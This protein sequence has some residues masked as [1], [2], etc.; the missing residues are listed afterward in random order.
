MPRLELWANGGGCIHET[1]LGAARRVAG[2]LSRSGVA[3]SSTR[4]NA[5]NVVAASLL[6]WGK[7]GESSCVPGV[8]I[9]GCHPY[10]RFV[11]IRA[12]RG[13]SPRPKEKEKAYQ[14]LNGFDARTS[15]ITTKAF[16]VPQ[17]HSNYLRPLESFAHGALGILR[18]LRRSFSPGSVQK[19]KGQT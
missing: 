14:G 13:D 18:F 19:P 2:V 8:E 6:L 16:Q 3:L 12:R 1:K 10:F 17:T 4:G 7:S 5:G 9:G 11:N 15:R